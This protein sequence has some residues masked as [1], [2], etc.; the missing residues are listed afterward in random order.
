MG[1][2]RFPRMTF[3]QG[4]DSI[5]A[6]GSARRAMLSSRKSMAAK[7]EF[8]NHEIASR[9]S[10]SRIRMEERKR[11]HYGSY[12]RCPVEYRFQQS[13]LSSR[14]SAGP[15]AVRL[16]QPERAAKPDLSP[17]L[18]AASLNASSICPNAPTAARPQRRHAPY[19][20][21]VLELLLLASWLRILILSCASLFPN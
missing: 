6:R 18:L 16:D 13:N 3:G 4:C 1:D 2:Q 9:I 14:N 15:R 8:R 17:R 11:S 7:L 12:D 21:E 10:N 20:L 19:L 5:F